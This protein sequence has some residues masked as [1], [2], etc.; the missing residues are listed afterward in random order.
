[1]ILEATTGCTRQL[2]VPGPH[3]CLRTFVFSCAQTAFFPF[4][5]QFV[6]IILQAQVSCNFLYKT[7]P[8][9]IT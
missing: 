6:N 2:T 7:L 8:N 1:M 3:Q 4:H 5:F 9:F